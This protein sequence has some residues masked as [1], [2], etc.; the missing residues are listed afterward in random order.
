[1][2]ISD[3]R[4]KVF[5]LSVLLLPLYN[6][7]ELYNLFYGV[8]VSQTIN[9]SGF[10]KFIK[11]ICLIFI[12]LVAMRHWISTAKFPRIFVYILLFY[13]FTTLPPL[14]VALMDQQFFNLLSGVRYLMPFILVLSLYDRI[15]KFFI[16]NLYLVLK[17]LFY[18]NLLLQFLQ[19]VFGSHYHGAIFGVFSARNTGFFSIPVTTAVFSSVFLLYRFVLRNMIKNT[20]TDK[21]LI[22]SM[23]AVC[24]AILAGS[25]TGIVLALIV[26]LGLLRLNVN[27]FLLFAS[28]MLVGYFAIDFLMSFRSPGALFVSFGTRVE[29]FVRTLVNGQ[30]VS[31]SFGN[32]TNSAVLL[33][34]G[35]VL[36]SLWA[37]LIHNLG[38]LGAISY[39]LSAFL[40]MLLA[41]VNRNRDRFL[42]WLF[43]F[44]V[45]S[46]SSILE[47]FPTAHVLG[48]LGIYLYAVDRPSHPYRVWNAH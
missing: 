12:F 7:G 23:G 1:M 31:Y 9:S 33:G 29:L 16:F 21:F 20:G 47:H 34:T 30:L 13:V 2:V 43:L 28:L 48:V 22:V 15:D 11:D 14:Y 19:L 41:F 45:S 3:V 39:F 4:V 24:S 5:M 42:Y 40:S 26:L 32:G 25:F 8:S 6:I 27:F 18:I 37:G 46:T 10:L 17:W 38:Y 35:V 36:D 44:A